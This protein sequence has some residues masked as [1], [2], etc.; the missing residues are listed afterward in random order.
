[1][2]FVSTGNYKKILTASTRASGSALA[3]ALV[4]MNASPARA[5]AGKEHSQ[6]QADP[7]AQQPA[8]SA[9]ADGE[10]AT[11]PTQ[12]TPA[13]GLGEIVVTARYRTENL[14]DS[15]LAI[16]ALTGNSLQ[17]RGITSMTQLSK[18]APNVAITP[19]GSAYGKSAQAFIRGVGQ[20]DWQLALDP[21]VSYYI[22]D[23]YFGRIFGAQFS[24]LDLDR[25][26]VLRGPQGTL[27]GKNTL[28]GAIRLYSEQP[29]GDYSG[30]IE[31]GIGSFHRRDIRGA[32]DLPIIADKVALRLAAASTTRRG[33]MTILDF[34]CVNP[35]QAGSLPRLSAREDCKLGTEGAE[36]VQTFRA[37][38]R[39]DLSD[40]LTVNLIGDIIDDHSESA[41]D[42]TIAIVPNYPGS[43]LGRTNT[44]TYIPEYGIPLD[45][46]FVT[47][48]P[49]TT[50]ATF[51][52][53]VVGLTVPNIAQVEGWGLSGKVEWQPS[54]DLTLK[55]ITAYR[56]FD[57][58]FSQDSDGSPLSAQLFY[59]LIE[60]RQFSQEVTL[61]GDMG[62]FNWTIGGFYYN[63]RGFNGGFIGLS[64]L[65]FRFNQFDPSHVKSISGFGHLVYDFTDRL[66]VEL[67]YR[68]THEKKDYT[69]DHRIY[70]GGALVFPVTEGDVS[71]NRS[72]YKAGINYKL[73]DDVLVYASVATG[74]KAGGINPRPITPA[75]ITTFNPEQ[76][77]SYEAGFKS[78]LFDRRVRFNL[79]AF[80]SDYRDL[81]INAYSTDRNG[82]L[83]L[84]FTNVGKARIQGV[85]A[86]LTGEPF[87]GFQINGSLGYLDYDAL[88]F[89]PAGSLAP[90]A[91]GLPPGEQPRQ[92]PN[93]TLYAGAQYT[94]ELGTGTLTPRIDFSYQSHIYNDF[95]NTSFGRE[96]AYG[97]LNAFLTYETA[98]KDW[99][100]QL[101]VTNLADKRYFVNRV[102][103]VESYGVVEGQPGRPR[104]WMVSLRR[105]F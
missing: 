59:N 31:A 34:A 48:D 2:V 50:Y 14:Q 76:I 40:T 8:T 39:A 66:S 10:G 22:D 72:D 38:L 19:S 12:E 46:R 15:P 70:P 23:V 93:L 91:D 96:P 102:V 5:G 60:H 56:A 42:K 49:F 62:P 71:Y 79:A 29:K 83:A 36:N 16:T 32:I 51:A 27:F 11:A 26:E 20:H 94:Q 61:T 4:A 44:N 80:L 52:D 90:R 37:Q 86:E 41:P 74:F 65:G 6:T 55:S 58:E 85:E 99:R 28:G 63:S 75:Q 77:T 13:E 82:V 45:S 3:M 78:E 101:Q 18:I 64:A 30:Y 57:G 67:G 24:L 54:P 25:V 68:F 81:Q 84:V 88:D 43:F 69:F 97:L 53:P 21:G 9:Q 104:E 103:T 92:V 105:S 47:A 17:N 98:N 100:L 87:D 35:S 95:A 33:Y 7:A 89:G 1:M 73:A